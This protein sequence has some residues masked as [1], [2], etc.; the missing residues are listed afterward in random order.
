MRSALLVLALLS[1]A[2]LVAGHAKLNNPLAWNPNPSTQQKCG[3]GTDPAVARASWP[4]GAK[5]A[6][7]IEWEVVAGDG[8][9]AITVKLDPNGGTDFT[10][11]VPITGT[12]PAT[13]IKYTFDITKVPNVE[14]KGAGGLCT[15]QIGNGNWVGCSTVEIT[16]VT[17]AAVV[18]A[19]GEPKCENLTGL[20]LCKA[21]E[22]RSGMIPYGTTM[23]AVDATLDTTIRATLFN[24]KVFDTPEGDG[25]GGAYVAYM[26]AKTFPSCNL[27]TQKETDVGPCNSV[28]LQAQNACGLKTDHKALLGCFSAT[29]GDKDN[30]GSCDTEYV[31]KTDL[32]PIS[33]DGLDGSGASQLISSPLAIVFTVLALLA[34][35]L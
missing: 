13:T 10:V 34:S 6:G 17:A 20:V 2:V 8:V 3:G 15:V 26:C 33:N 35:R 4:S 21:M 19:P 29:N 30:Y 16:G 1:S 28:C 24:P 12:T 14:C 32:Q 11:N 9:G 18:V 31:G 7:A 25:C 22:G 5:V 27:L 23:E